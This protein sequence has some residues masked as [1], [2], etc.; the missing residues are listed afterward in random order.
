MN[1]IFW[2]FYIQLILNLSSKFSKFCSYSP[3]FR[4]A[5]VRFCW[6]ITDVRICSAETALFE[7]TGQRDLHRKMSHTW[8]FRIKNPRNLGKR[9]ILLP[10]AHCFIWI[11]S[12][13]LRFQ[14]FCYSFGQK[15]GEKGQMA[16]DLCLK[17]LK[18]IFYWEIR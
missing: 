1:E 2:V 10:F 13:K 7:D 15:S 18:E 12:M 14:I 11:F 9:K 4:Y 17:Y 8:P 5:M 3:D 16:I 6:E